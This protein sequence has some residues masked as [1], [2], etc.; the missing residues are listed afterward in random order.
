MTPDTVLSGTLNLLLLEDSLQ[1]AELIQEC[2]IESGYELIIE[3]VDNEKE[4]VNQLNT[5]RFNIILSDFNLPGFDGMMALDWVM[6]L[7]PEIPFICISG[8]ISEEV[9]VDMLKKGAIDFLMKDRIK[10]LPFA[11]ADALEKKKIEKEK[12]EAYQMLRKSEERYSQIVNTAN[13]GIRIVDKNYFITFVNSQMAE[14]LGYKADELINIP[15]RN[16]IFHEE[17]EKYDKRIETRVNGLADKSFESRLIKKDGTILWVLVSSTPILDKNNEFQGSFAMVTDITERKNAEIIL[18]ESEARLQ[19]LLNSVTDYIYLVEIQ[20]GNVTNTTHGEGCIAVTGYSDKYFKGN[21]YHWFNIIHEDDRELVSEQSFKLTKGIKVP[22]VEHRIIHKNGDIRWVRNTTVLRYNNECELIGYDG[23]ITD[24]TERK[25]L[26][27]QILNS[28]IETEERERLNFSQE[29]HDGIGPLL[30][31]IKMYVQW[32]EMPDAQLNQ[33]KILK[34]IEKL[35]DESS[36]TV[37]EISFRLNPHILQ[38]Y[39]LIEALKAYTEKIMESANV[40]VNLEYYNMCQLDEK[41]KTITY[42]VLCE[43]TNNTV[44]H[45]D[46]DRID[47]RMNCNNEILNVEYSDNGKGFDVNNINQK[48]IGLLNMQSRIRSLNGSMEIISKPSEGTNIKFQLRV[49]DI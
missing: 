13:E 6:K 8:H 33:G 25:M 27:S 49:R 15:L 11:I 20:K 46:A 40:L 31:A 34:N 42:R 14:M 18:Q 12:E 10:R 35:L 4:F 9:A 36:N 39:G 7:C 21:Y 45:A 22:P 44:K 1:D 37:R 47:I 26:E 41:V 23:L 30:S 29:L 3:R 19:K 5:G 28:I 16:L 48:G 24:I 43:C 2:I 38:N 32:L 17:L